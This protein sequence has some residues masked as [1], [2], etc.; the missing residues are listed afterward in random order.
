MVCLASPALE[1]VQTPLPGV[2][3]EI[4]AVSR[5][6]AAESMY[7]RRFTCVQWRAHL[8]YI[9]EKRFLGVI[10]PLFYVFYA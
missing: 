6:G 3:C 7:H 5:G 4:S 1:N 10:L 8:Y 2:T 9:F